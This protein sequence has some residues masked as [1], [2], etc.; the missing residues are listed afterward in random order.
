LSGF[1]LGKKKGSLWSDH[2]IAAN[3]VTI[4]PKFVMKRL[5]KDVVIADRFRVDEHNSILNEICR[6]L[7]AQRSVIHDRVSNLI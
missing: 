7:K 6:N 2:Y 3:S 5:S 4:C 1:F